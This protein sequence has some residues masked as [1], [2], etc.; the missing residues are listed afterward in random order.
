[1][2]VILPIELDGSYAGSQAAAAIFCGAS[3]CPL[4]VLTILEKF[5]GV[6][7][8]YIGSTKEITE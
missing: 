8:T 1:M 3:R 6:T 4:K 5:D 7:L 2:A